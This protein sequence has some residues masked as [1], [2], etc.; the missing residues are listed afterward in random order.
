MTD[1]LERFADLGLT[2]DG[3][4]WARWCRPSRTPAGGTGGTSRRGGEKAQEGVA[5]SMGD[6][7]KQ[8]N[9][10]LPHA[11]S[12][13]LSIVDRENQ[14]HRTPSRVQLPTDRS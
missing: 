14:E 1:T 12:R 5:E 4:Y 13:A 9:T 3:A 8:R 11:A 2:T 7:R 6:R 10:R